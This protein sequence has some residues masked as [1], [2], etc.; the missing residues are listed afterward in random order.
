MF[1]VAVGEFLAVSCLGYVIFR[2]IMK[3]PGLMARLKLAV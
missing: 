2:Q 3:N 1:T